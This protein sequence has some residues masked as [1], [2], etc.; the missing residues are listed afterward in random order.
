[1]NSTQLRKS[2]WSRLLRGV[3]HPP[4][5]KGPARLAVEPLEDRCL[6][7]QLGFVIQPLPT[8]LGDFL[9]LARPAAR[10]ERRGV[11][12]MGRGPP[13]PCVRATARA[14]AEAPRCHF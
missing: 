5:A 4:R 2:V 12:E 7:A 6:P 1:M 13:A 3:S 11:P 9:K 8:A 10:E 14:R